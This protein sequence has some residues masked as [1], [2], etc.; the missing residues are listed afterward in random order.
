[1]ATLSKN[2]LDRAFTFITGHEGFSATAYPDGQYYSIGYGHNSPDIQPGDTVTLEEARQYWESDV[3]KTVDDISRW[4]YWD[5]LTDNQQ[6]ALTSFAYN[7]GTGSFWQ[8]VRD[9]RTPEELAQ[10]WIN[11]YHSYS[12]ANDAGLK[13]RRQDEINLFNTKD[14]SGVSVGATSGTSSSGVGNFH[15]EIPSSLDRI[16]NDLLTG[17]NTVSSNVGA[18]TNTANNEFLNAEEINNLGWMD[19][20]TLAMAGAGVTLIIFNLFRMKK[21]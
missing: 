4:S 18:A 8:L 3:Q 11:Y 2:W 17:I 21:R 7:A 20:A 13:Q 1:M 12:S 19:I 14:A 6:I 9:G 16:K 10:Y 15:I 5:D